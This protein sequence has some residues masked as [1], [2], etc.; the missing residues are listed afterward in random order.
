MGALWR[1]RNKSSHHPYCVV[2]DKLRNFSGPSPISPLELDHKKHQKVEN[3]E[4]A[5]GLGAMLGGVG[6]LGAHPPHAPSGLPA[7]GPRPER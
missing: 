7:T 2:L 4:W 6:L 3:A 1:S 5:V